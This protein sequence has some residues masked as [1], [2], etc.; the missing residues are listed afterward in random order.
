M[1][2]KRKE[3]K[4]ETYKETGKSLQEAKE[5]PCES[6]QSVGYNREKLQSSGYTPER[7]KERAFSS[8]KGNHDLKSK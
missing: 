5:T 3:K 6:N 1:K 8:T 7:E 2:K 4:S